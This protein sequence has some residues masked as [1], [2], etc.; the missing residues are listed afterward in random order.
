MTDSSSG[1]PTGPPTGSSTAS[2]AGSGARLPRT[3]ARCLDAAGITDPGLRADVEHCRR[4]HALHGRTYYLATW[5]LP[6][7]RRPWVWSLYGFFRTA[8]ELVDAVP[9]PDPALLR[10]WAA[11][12]RA[13]VDGAPA[14][15]PEGPAGSDD[16]SVRALLA[17]LRR[18]DLDPALVDSFLTSMLM[19]LEVA[20]YETYDDLLEY[21]EGSARVVG[22]MMLPVLGTARG[23]PLAEAA[24][25]AALLG[26]AF[27]LTNFVRDV[28]EDLDRGRLYLPAQDL[29]AAGLVR[30]DLEALRAQP[31]GADARPPRAVVDLLEREIERCHDLYARA[32]PGIA[33][34]DP[35]T[36]PG[37]Q[38]ATTLYGEILDRVRRE[39]YP[40]LRRRVRVPGPRRAA[41]AAATIGAGL[42]ARLAPA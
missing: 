39:G 25:Y 18:H 17:T 20:G 33:L 2:S 24:P 19:D 26:E 12:A 1:A 32:R 10:D 22:L 8:D 38:A 34:L 36:R 37:V 35:R 41:V 27:Q 40:V 4:L 5:L 42:R 31:S 28:G 14:G 11:G 6:P 15:R 7:D 29:A 13:A 30:E 16:P 21:V 3:S 9:T 23:V